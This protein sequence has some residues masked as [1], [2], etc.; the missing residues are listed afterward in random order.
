MERDR[1]SAKTVVLRRAVPPDGQRREGSEEMRQHTTNISDSGS[2]AFDRLTI[3]CHA[4]RSRVGRLTTLRVAR[5]RRDS[6]ILT[7]GGGRVRPALR[8]PL[9]VVHN[10]NRV[11]SS[12]GQPCKRSHRTESSQLFV[13]VL[14]HFCSVNACDPSSAARPH[15]VRTGQRGA[16]SSSCIVTVPYCALP[17]WQEH[18]E[19]LQPCHAV[20]PLAMIDTSPSSR[21]RVGYTRSST[22]SR[23]VLRDGPPART[24]HI[25]RLPV[26]VAACRPSRR[27][28]S[29]L[30]AYAAPTLPSY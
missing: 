9:V 12:P 1:P 15:R 13:Y 3:V 25:S 2:S 19:Q 18:P 22:P 4:C 11:T 8:P 23:C 7:R 29:P 20:A 14:A 6:A 10:A 16:L 27:V 26:G 30:W 21:Q 24:R 28:A 17:A 5:L